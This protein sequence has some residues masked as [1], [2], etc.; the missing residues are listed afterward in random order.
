[1]GFTTAVRTCFQKYATFSG[2]APRPEYWWWVLF[3][4]VVSVVVM[5]LT[6]APTGGNTIQGL[7]SLALLLPSLAVGARRLHDMGRSGWW[8]LLGLI[9]VLGFLVLLFWFVQPGQAGTNRFGPSPV[10]TRTQ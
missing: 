2:R 3:Q 5:A 1:M 7:V 8:L 6:G 10:P 9:P 4:V